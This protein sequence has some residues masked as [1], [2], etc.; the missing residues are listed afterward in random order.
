MCPKAGG[1]SNS[2]LPFLAPLLLLG[3]HPRSKQGDP[4]LVLRF[5][6]FAVVLCLTHTPASPQH[7]HSTHKQGSHAH[8]PAGP[9][10]PRGFGGLLVATQDI[11]KE[12]RRLAP[13]A[14]LLALDIP[15]QTCRP[16]N[17]LPPH[18]PRTRTGR[19]GVA[20]LS[21]AGK[22]HHH[23]LPAAASPPLFLAALASSP[24]NASPP[25]QPC[26]S[27]R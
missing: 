27:R 14:V 5:C 6:L 24:P 26:T 13:P 11:H 17:T 18:P 12:E 9:P 8:G 1:A 16:T 4:D 20:C 19:S 3:R 23:L 2:F 15:K 25:P 10:F 7:T 22:Q 21:T